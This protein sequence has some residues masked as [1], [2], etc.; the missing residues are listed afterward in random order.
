MKKLLKIFS[1]IIFFYI[2]VKITD[3]T[4]NLVV[5]SILGVSLD[6]DVYLGVL[7]IPDILLIL[8][9]FDSIKG[10]LNSEFSSLKAILKQL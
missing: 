4:K 3:V 1:T 6:A 2:V 8:I 5:A 7:N 9:G 10:V